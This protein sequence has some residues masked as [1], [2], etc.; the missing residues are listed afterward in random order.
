MKPEQSAIRTRPDVTPAIFKHST[1]ELVRQSILRTEG[2][3]SSVLVVENSAAIRCHPEGTVPRDGERA[4]VVV[5]HGGRVDAGVDNKPY[6]IESCEPTGCSQT[7]RYPSGVWEMARIRFSG[8]PSCVR[9]IRL[10]Y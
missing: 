5:S 6:A 8:S 2:L 10:T 4:D 3:K 7:Q 9:Q 1:D